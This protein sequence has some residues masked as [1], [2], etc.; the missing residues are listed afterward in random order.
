MNDSWINAINSISILW[1][2][3]MLRACWQSALLALI[4]WIICRFWKR[5]NAPIRCGLWWLVCLKML[6]SLVPA[7][8]PLPLLAKSQ[9]VETTITQSAGPTPIIYR[10]SVTFSAG[11]S[12]RT[13]TTPEKP[14]RQALSLSS[15]L[16]IA[17]VLGVAICMLR[18]II[19]LISLY[20]IAWK[21]ST[22][23]EPDALRTADIA[24]AIVGLRRAPRL[25][26]TDAPVGPLLLD[27]LDRLSFSRKQID[28]SVRRMNYA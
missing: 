18:S 19:F 15:I 21:A 4:V 25:L 3:A 9:V 8:F 1:R 17:W 23:Y 16:F 27:S 2:D 22:I 12:A 13:H 7:A 5:I 10:N 20:R 24:A 6:L 11:S 26:M 14:T 28:I